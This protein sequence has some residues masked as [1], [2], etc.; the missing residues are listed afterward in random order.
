MRE[1]L[2]L[3][4]PAKQRAVAD[5]LS[6]SGVTVRGLED[7]IVYT[8]YKAADENQADRILGKVISD[9]DGA[10]ASIRAL[11]G[12]R[13]EHEARLEREQAD[14]AEREQ[15][16]QA[17]RRERNRMDYENRPQEGEDPD[18]W[19]RDQRA[20]RCWCHVHGD[21]WSRDRV[22]AEVGVEADELDALLERGASLQSGLDSGK[23]DDKRALCFDDPETVEKRR[24][25]FIKDM[26][27]RRA[28]R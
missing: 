5:G 19:E 12:W 24:K 18:Q 11:E 4:S 3:L 27:E 22:I 25:Q 16:E 9:S 14:A 13:E 2:F 17:E 26:R 1:R 6:R 28:G 21:R 20:I 15:R 8:R 23:T 10:A 7:L